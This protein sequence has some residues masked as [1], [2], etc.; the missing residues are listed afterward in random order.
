MK[1]DIKGWTIVVA[2]SWNAQ[3][4]EPAWVGE[5]LF[6]VKELEI[7]FVFHRNSVFPSLKTS[8]IILS[9]TNSQIVCGV[10]T[11]S[12]DSLTKAEN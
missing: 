1:P 5:K 4:F 7:E 10:R 8:D 11:L 6:G 9:P 12:E 3:I 2:G